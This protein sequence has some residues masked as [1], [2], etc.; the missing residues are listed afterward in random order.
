MAHLHMRVLFSIKKQWHTEPCMW[1]DRTR[2]KH[3]E[4]GNIDPKRW[5]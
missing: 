2:E 5:T 1:M 3:P 4:W